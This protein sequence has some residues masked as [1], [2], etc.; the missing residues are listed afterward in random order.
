MG[1]DLL[2]ENH[3]HIRI[4]HFYSREKETMSSL[5]QDLLELE[6]VASDVDTCISEAELWDRYGKNQTLNAIESGLLEHRRIKFRE[7]Y[8][9]CVC[10]LSD[11]GR[12]VAATENEISPI[13]T[14]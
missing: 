9:R 12:K 13:L 2:Y 8:G 10:W 6:Q 7:G 11:K 5:L 1:S 4:N 14:N 3:S